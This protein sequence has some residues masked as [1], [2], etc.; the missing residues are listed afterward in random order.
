MAWNISGTHSETTIYFVYAILWTTHLLTR[1]DCWGE[2]WT[3]QT[4][5]KI[6]KEHNQLWMSPVYKYDK[7]ILWGASV[8]TVLTLDLDY[9]V[10]RK[11]CLVLHRTF[12]TYP[13]CTLPSSSPQTGTHICIKRLRHLH[14]RYTYGIDTAFLHSYMVHFIS[15]KEALNDVIFFIWNNCGINYYIKIYQRYLN[16]P[17]LR[18]KFVWNQSFWQKIS[19]KNICPPC[20]CLKYIE[21]YI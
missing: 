13:G 5:K 10:I 19:L 11:K 4:I 9:K 8:N 18:S 2:S 20:T 12:W 7:I 14:W 16:Y 15:H 1:K 21:L 3:G 17:T 6:S